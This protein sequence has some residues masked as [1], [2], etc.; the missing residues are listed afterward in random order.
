MNRFM[1]SVLKN[2]VLVALL[3]VG[4]T[5]CED[6]DPEVSNDQELITKVVLTVKKNGTIVDTATFSDKDGAGGAAPTIEGLTLEA[7]TTYETEIEFFDESK[8]PAED[9]TEEID[10]EKEAHQV[11]YTPSNGLGV[12]ASYKDKDSN[13]QP[14]GLEMEMKTTNAATG[15]LKITLKHEPTKS[16]ANAINTGET[17]VEVELPISIL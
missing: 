6:D 4:F 3:L 5:S 13:N 10:E 15:T 8:N 1:K 11:F 2:Y 9:I 17:D 16:S 14:V 7:N 12:S